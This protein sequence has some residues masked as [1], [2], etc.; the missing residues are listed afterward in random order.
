M[1]EVTA[2][3]VEIEREQEL[4]VEPKYRLNCCTLMIKLLQMSCFL[5]MSKEVL[6]R[7]GIYSW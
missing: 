2:D 4:E 7:D 5:C 1:E 3:M 6:S